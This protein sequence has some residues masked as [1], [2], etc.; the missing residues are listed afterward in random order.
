MVTIASIGILAIAL[1]L[2]T[3]I[4]GDGLANRQQRLNLAMTTF[5]D[6]VKR[7]DWI[8]PA[9]P[10]VGATPPRSSDPNLSADTSPAG[11]ILF[12][13]VG[14]DDVDP[15]VPRSDPAVRQLRSE[16]VVFS[17]TDLQYWDDQFFTG[18]G[19]P[20]TCLTQNVSWPVA[21]LKLKVCFTGDGTDGC[22]ADS[23]VVTSGA[24]MMG[25]RSLSQGT[26]G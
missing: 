25:P 21:K 2:L 18:N 16:G 10:A 3:S 12:G 4:R 11:R 8:A 22:A 13:I 1:G 20:A 24:A 7:A 23:P 26:T 15:G 9:C 14:E 6:S 5:A 17:I 19:F